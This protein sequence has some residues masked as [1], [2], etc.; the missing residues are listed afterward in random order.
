MPNE[1]LDVAGNKYISRRQEQQQRQE[2]FGSWK[3]VQ[4]HIIIFSFSF[5]VSHNTERHHTRDTPPHL[6]EARATPLAHIYTAPPDLPFIFILATLLLLLFVSFPTIQLENRVTTIFIHTWI[7][8]E[9]RV[10]PP[11]PPTTTT[12]TKCG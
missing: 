3:S 7:E 10:L 1:K 12:K 9:R 6:A 2:K 5:I 11:A 4:L 8:K